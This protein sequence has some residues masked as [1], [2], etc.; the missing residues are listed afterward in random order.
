MGKRDDFDFQRKMMDEA[1]EKLNQYIRAL[2]KEKKG[3]EVRA[4]GEE[5]Y[6]QIA[7]TGFIKRIIDALISQYTDNPADAAV[8]PEKADEFVRQ[9]LSGKMKISGPKSETNTSDYIVIHVGEGVTLKLGRDNSGNCEVSVCV[10]INVNNVTNVNEEISGVS[11]ADP[12]MPDGKEEAK[13]LWF[14]ADQLDA[15]CRAAE[16]IF[17]NAHEFK[18]WAHHEWKQCEK[19]K[20]LDYPKKDVC[21]KIPVYWWW[22]WLK[23]ASEEDL[24]DLEFI[25]KIVAR[26]GDCL[27]YALPA[28]KSDR[29]TVLSAIKDTGYA[30]IYASEELQNDREFVLQALE[31][32]RNVFGHVREMFRDDKG[33][34]LAAVKKNGSNLQYVSERL[35][36]DPDV[37]EAALAHDIGYLRYASEAFRG[38]KEYVMR[39]VS[40]RGNLLES[41]SERLKAD[42]DVVL[43]AVTARGKALQYASDDMKSD[44]EVVLAAVKSDGNALE[45]ASELL[46]NDREIVLMAVENSRGALA[47]ASDELRDDR[48]VAIGALKG[49]KDAWHFVSNRLLG[50][51][52]FIKAALTAGGYEIIQKVPDET[53]K[54][55]DAAVSLLKNLSENPPDMDDYGEFADGTS[56]YYNVFKRSEDAFCRLVEKLTAKNLKNNPELM[57]KICGLAASLDSTYYDEGNYPYEYMHTRL[58]DRLKAYFEKNG[59]SYSDAIA[60]AI[61]ARE[62][63]KYHQKEYSEDIP[64]E[65]RLFLEAGDYYEWLAE[66]IRR[67]DGGEAFAEYLGP[68]GDWIDHV[69]ERFVKSLIANWEGLFHNDELWSD[70]DYAVDLDKAYEEINKRLSS[71]MKV[72]RNAFEYYYS[73]NVKVFVNEKVRFK[74]VREVPI[75]VLELWV[76]DYDTD[77]ERGFWVAPDRLDVFCNMA[78]YVQDNYGAFEKKAAARAAK[79]MEKYIK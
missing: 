52:E 9:R 56:E 44:R 53:L 62:A 7:L 64:L 40:E 3:K 8:S 67:R 20:Y 77:R 51:A 42:R 37:V 27:Q 4:F 6:A 39:A 50:D 22:A 38:N 41:L 2:L 26:R 25:Q 55:A 46:R 24:S 21:D 65:E 15:F 63:K 18:E 71:K 23:N 17:D 76:N 48:E 75:K 73:E 34:A 35:R 74:L 13:S 60:K 49:D 54:D 11:P 36:N 47:H 61:E 70:E 14:A 31:A 68:Q 58:P 19:Y 69:M 33:V 78:E 12:D 57:D 32:N 10:P 45:F 1:T 66:K 5:K 16:Y 43:S 30:I 59:I 28:S 29:T 79:L 72:E